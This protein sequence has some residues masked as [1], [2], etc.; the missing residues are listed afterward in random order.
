M[1]V[2]EMNDVIGIHPMERVTLQSR[3][4]Q[5]LRQLLMMGRFRPG[6]V[7]K[8]RDLA[9]AFGTSVQPIREAIRQLI[10]E[11]ALE[12]APNASAMVP[13]LTLD[14]L[15]DLRLVR[16][17][18][19]GLAAELAAQTATADD[20]KVLSDIIHAEQSADDSLL[21]EDSVSRNLD[22]HF[23]LYAL[24]GSAELISIIEG[25]WLRIG[26]LIRDVAEGFDATDGKGAALHILMLKALS[27]RDG[28]M[29]RKALEQDIGRFFDLVGGRKAAVTGGGRVKARAGGAAT[30]VAVV[31]ATDKTAAKKARTKVR[32]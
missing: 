30:P 14:Q 2:D 31:A 18:I 24:S 4:H 9:S 26:P 19:E 25:L 1:L 3:V 23:R 21:V 29:L 20:V 7:L 11:R 8:I 15:D 16:V 13:K 27:R 5:E 28:A 17:A 12:A 6:Q 32:A 22:F 10:A